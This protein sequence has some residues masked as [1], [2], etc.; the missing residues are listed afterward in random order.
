VSWLSAAAGALGMVLLAREAVAQV[1]WDVGASEGVVGRVLAERPPGQ[2]EARP[3]MALELVGHAAVYPLLR[4][5]AY[6]HFDVSAVAAPGAF[7]ARQMAAGGLD[8]RVLSLWPRGQFRAYL[9]VALGEACSF[10][11]SHAAGAP[12]TEGYFTEVPVGAG[13]AYRI[14]PPLWLTAESGARI[15][16]AFGGAAYGA[17][18]SVGRDVVAGYATIGLAW[19]R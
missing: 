4:V 15:G 9:R 8:L 16:F 7:V 14:H 18:V 5:G 11:P 10:L 17:G 3:G 12:A 1:R 2:G 6:G 19:G 13:L